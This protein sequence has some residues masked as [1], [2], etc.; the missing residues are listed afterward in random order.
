MSAKPYCHKNGEIVLALKFTGKL[1]GDGGAVDLKNFCPL[2]WVDVMATRLEICISNPQNDRYVEFRLKEGE[3]LVRNDDSLF[4]VWSERE[5]KSYF[6][7]M[8][9]AEC[10]VEIANGFKS[11]VETIAPPLMF[12]GVPIEPDPPV[13]INPPELNSDAVQFELLQAHA[14]VSLLCSKYLT[15]PLTEEERAEHLKKIESILVRLIKL[16]ME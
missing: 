5:F 11:Q 4:R 1:E 8:S 7:E 2:A 14:R 10:A 3:W 12:R 6:E 13:S 9:V 16:K 15:K